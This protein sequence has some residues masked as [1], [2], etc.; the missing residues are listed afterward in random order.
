MDA[1]FLLLDFGYDGA[2][3]SGLDCVQSREVTTLDD[4]GLWDDLLDEFVSKGGCENRAGAE[5]SEDGEDD[6]GLH[7]E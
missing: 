5:G 2:S 3:I 4:L 7:F 6:R 1:K